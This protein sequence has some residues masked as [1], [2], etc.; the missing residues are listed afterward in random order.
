[1]GAGVVGW[2]TLVGG[3]TWTAVFSGPFLPWLLPRRVSGWVGR[4][5]RCPPPPRIALPKLRR[6]AAVVAVT[7]F[8][9]LGFGGQSHAV[10]HKLAHLGDNLVP[11]LDGVDIV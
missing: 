5:L 7:G 10:Y 6:A 4:A 1:M 3:H 11:E 2:C 9:A 8:L